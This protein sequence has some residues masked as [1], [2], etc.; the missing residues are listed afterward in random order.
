MTPAAAV[1]RARELL[2]EVP[3]AHP[4]HAACLT[5]LGIALL[6]LFELDGDVAVL[7]EAATT[8]HA[9]AAETPPDDPAFVARQFNA[10]QTSTVLF[11][12]TGH[13]KPL[14]DAAEAAR[15][16][17]D[18]LSPDEPD[19]AGMLIPLGDTLQSAFEWL[20]D[21]SDLRRAVA[22]FQSARDDLAPD[23]RAHIGCGFRL[24]T[25]LRLVYERTDDLDALGE[26]I[27]TGR[28]TVATT[29]R[30]NPYYMGLRVS[31]CNALRDRYKRTGDAEALSE[32]LSL[33]RQAAAAVPADHPNG[34]ITLNVLGETLTEEYG[35]T[36]DLTVLRQAVAAGRDA[37]D[38]LQPPYLYR[39]TYQMNLAWRLR[40]LADRLH[41]RTAAREA[42]LLGRE[43]VAGHASNDPEL[44]MAQSV[45]GG[46]LVQLAQLEG[47]RE[48]ML[49]AVKVA[50]DAREATPYDHAEYV[51]R[52][53][54]LVAALMGL[55][56]AS[57]VRHFL[58]R[59]LRAASNAAESIPPDH[60]DRG[61]VLMNLCE[62]LRAAARAGFTGLDLTQAERY[63]RAAVETIPLVHPGRADLLLS[64]GRVLAIK[65]RQTGAPTAALEC[66]NVYNAA[67]AMP[68]AAPADRVVAAHEAAETAMLAGRRNQAMRMAETA[69]DLVPRMIVRDVGRADRERRLRSVHGLAATAAAAAIS[70]QRP[71]R[72][73]ELL[74][75]A[76]GLVLAS[77]LDTRSDLTELRSL[78]PDLAAPF[79]E[80]RRA[81]NTLDHES[82]TLDNTMTAELGARVHALAGRR[83]Q[84]N[85]EWDRQLDHIRR[86][87]GLERFLRPR[88]IDELGAQASHGPIVYLTVHE[89]QG[90]ALTV[91]NGDPVH[92][93]ALP[94][95]VTES[96][97][98]EMVSALRAASSSD[99]NQTASIAELQAAQQRTLDILGWTWDNI[100]EPVLRQLGH[101]GAGPEHGPWPRI[102]W[103]PVGQFAF[104]PLHAAG[105]HTDE[106]RADSVLDR[107]VSSYTPSIRALAHARQRAPAPSTSAVVVAVPDAPDSAP[108]TSA[109]READ[110]VRRFI[111]DAAVLP[112]PN[113]RTNH[114]SA[115]AALRRH[116]IAHLAC[117]GVADRHDPANS[118]LI[119]HDHLTCPLTMHDITQ[120]HLRSAQLA[121]LSAC[122]TT[123]V[124]TLQVDEATQLTA[125]FQLAG[126]RNVIGTLWPISDRAAV[127][128]ARE[129][130]H[131]LTNG[132]TTP[133][134][135]DTVAEALHGAIRH[136]RQ[137]RP[138]MPTQWAGYIHYGI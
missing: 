10:S 67:A 21:L 98:A 136:Q 37:I 71:E 48:L 109:V 30:D 87:P 70:V 32:A 68:T 127:E 96:K 43:S 125:A 99:T 27:E 102:W 29:P 63:A 17:L 119:L 1:R 23:N 121:Y 73:V 65:A 108:L 12:S 13:T 86:R 115:I 18:A 134:A 39:A 38:A 28:A 5:D 40:I 8:C 19:R 138:M 107:V 66:V 3:Q 20:G 118:R 114:A 53:T 88:L 128:M 64:L 14:T 16:V 51:G 135:L 42:V 15:K 59:A 75:Q 45:L 131:T 11:K 50:D 81:V 132:G 95:E 36:G 58:E 123:D 74:E 100:T 41:D 126:Y 44:P 4:E 6:R 124:N 89:K 54:T 110:T 33:I 92:A 47:D 62:V 49:E 113:T 116:G 106:S 77:T 69:V 7:G 91:R 57:N 93:L 137:R 82:T 31:L 22:A 72:A 97:L 80:L 105:R 85:Q 122:S 9:A 112:E 83:E 60:A 94:P 129:V 24:C 130:Y 2:A 111:P 103:C 61:A 79:D 76:R 34:A 78:A 120:L 133:P 35:R 55:Y 90:H 84:L 56:R 52:L 25:A 26:A 104:L 46:A 117:H 101:V